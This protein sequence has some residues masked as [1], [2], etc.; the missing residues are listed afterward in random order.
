MFD[1]LGRSVSVLHDGD[2]SAGDKYRFAID[3]SN[4]PGGVYLIRAT[5]RTFTASRQVVLVR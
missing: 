4:L 1:L 5:G 2:M 3:G